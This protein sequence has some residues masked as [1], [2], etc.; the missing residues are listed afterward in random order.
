MCY[1]LSTTYKKGDRLAS[2]QTGLP[3]PPPATEET[4]YPGATS[5]EQYDTPEGKMV[6]L[7]F[8]IPFKCY[9][10]EMNGDNAEQISEGLRSSKI[11]RPTPDEIAK[12][13]RD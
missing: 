8:Y 9:T 6:R 10:I 4:I 3:F 12:V 13:I 7:K 1:A 5:I 11:V 2:N